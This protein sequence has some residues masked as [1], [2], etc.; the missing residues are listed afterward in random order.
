MLFFFTV[1]LTVIG[2][3]QATK[4]WIMHHFVLHESRVVIPD[5]FNLTYLTNN[6]A[7]FSILAGQPALW[8][9]VFFIA[10]AGAA[11]VFIW[12]AQRSFGRRSM[13]YTLGLALIAGGAIGNLI[14]RIRFGFVIDF[15]DVY[16]GTYHWPA[17]NIADSAITVGV[18]LFIVNNLLFDRQQSE[19]A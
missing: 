5:L 9:Q 13:A 4:F 12:I 17:F 2:L 1:I 7:A 19:R 6:G 3:D 14:D 11:L 16:V 10:A 18:I 8:R 15:L